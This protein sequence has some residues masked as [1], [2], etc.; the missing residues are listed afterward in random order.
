VNGFGLLGEGLAVTALV[1][2]IMVL[3]EYL[4]VAT[5]GA[6]GGLARHR[7]AAAY[8]GAALL[9][10]VPG[11]LG[12]FAA[13]SLDTHGAMSFGAIVTTMIATSGDEAFV[14]LALFPREAVLLFVLLFVY[15]VVF[16]ALV[17]R[18]VPGR[19]PFG[20]RCET[21][22][23]VHGEERRV[24]L[25]ALRTP[26]KLTAPRAGLLVG[27]VVVLAAVA[28][29]QVGPGGW[30]PIRV[31]LLVLTA[32]AS[33]IV[34]TVPE[35][36]LRE[37][38]WRHVVREHVPKVLL[39]V[40]VVLLAVHALESLGLPVAETAREHPGWALVAAAILGVIPQSG[41]HLVFVTL[42]AQGAV[43]FSV[44]ATSSVVQD[45]HGALPLLADSWRE[46]LRVKT[47]NLVAGLV[48]GSALMA[49]GW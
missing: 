11:C 9:G 41:P 47:V 14:M 38:L 18:V 30:G 40:S 19:A 46:F 33:W 31:T 21:G 1:A 10:A 45:G 22:L 4:N 3:V 43:P 6:L 28:T 37:H 8:S 48:L 25:G 24:V 27:L 7:G 5:A 42:F 2:V 39:W 17:D 13:T 35:H 32:L 29:G 15:G 49:L 23:A 34:A 16:G 20:P 26:Q 12:T 44:L 36:F